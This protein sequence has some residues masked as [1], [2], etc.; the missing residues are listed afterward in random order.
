[1]LLF[2]LF[3]GLPETSWAASDRG[4][5]CVP[6]ARALS[7]V[8][9]FG[10]AWRWWSAAAGRFNRGA[11]PQAGS[12][13]S[14]RSD[15]RMPL[16]HIAVVTKVIDAREIE[17]DHANWSPG[18]VGRQVRVLDVSAGNDWTVVR[19]ELAERDHFGAVYG[20]NGFIYGWPAEP[21]PQII[22][23]A[24]ALQTF[25]DD[26]LQRT[27]G[28]GPVVVGPQGVIA[29]NFRGRALPVVIDSRRQAGKGATQK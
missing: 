3:A 25:R 2:A 24:E 21:G 29:D 14:F 9:L 5:Q 10:D 17:V 28:M 23:V 13:L 18:V 16:G 20:T 1:M 11:T 27:A 6:F 12:I 19:V 15:L 26:R 22:K 4:P 8:R 7:S